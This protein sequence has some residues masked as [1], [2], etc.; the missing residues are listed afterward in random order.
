MISSNCR[1]A[2]TRAG[3][4]LHLASTLSVAPL[5]AP[6]RAQPATSPS[7][8]GS[9]T[10]PSETVVDGA[11]G[12]EIDRWL[13]AADFR[14]NLLVARRGVILFC[15]GYGKSDREDGVPYDRSTVFS[16]GSITK[17]F[18]AAA[19]LKLEM[20]GKL[21]VEDTLSKHLPGVPEDKR[22]ITLHHLLTHTSGL[23][24]DFAGDFEPVGRDEYVRR[25]LASKLRS[26][27]GEIW[28]YANSGYSLLGAIVELV[29]GKPYEQFLRENLFL[30]AGM[31]E[32]G[33]RLPH[34]D[35]RR[36]AVGYK[37]GKRRGRLA[38]NHG[39]KMDHIGRCGPTEAYTPRSTICSCGIP[40]CRVKPYSPGRRRQRC[41]R[42]TFERGPGETP[43]TGTAGPSRTFPGP[44][45]SSVTMVGMAFSTPTSRGSSTRTWSSFFRRTTRLC[46]AG[47]SRRPSRVSPMAS[48]YRCRL[49]A[50]ALLSR[51]QP[52]DA[53][54]SSVAGWMPST[55]PTL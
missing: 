33:Y 29:S 38:D 51:S 32:T 43:S 20:Q 55:R 40:P 41:M 50:A 14:G 46:V 22:A 10:A 5:L 35:L 39:L 19:I 2:L 52:P 53:R 15:K 8:S 42:R 31:K 49:P 37:D 24:S 25:I 17:Q 27:P 18:T 48:T 45:G 26:K 12:A 54:R 4:F 11:M 6:A 44:A 9:Q 28:F 7:P 36:I 13:T 34:W 21:H 23:E 16:I 47:E 30:P 1:S 3:F